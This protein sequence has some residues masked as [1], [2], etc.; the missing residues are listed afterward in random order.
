MRTGT[1]PS[2]QGHGPLVDMY[3]ESLLTAFEMR[4]ETRIMKESNYPAK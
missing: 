1:R 3:P 2:K 4:T